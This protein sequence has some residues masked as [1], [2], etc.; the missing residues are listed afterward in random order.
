MQALKKKKK[1]HWTVLT[2]FMFEH[3]SA[4]SGQSSGLDEGCGLGKVVGGGPQ[5]FLQWCSMGPLL[6]SCLSEEGAEL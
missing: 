2:S 6:C 1:G 5:L 4:S 3:G